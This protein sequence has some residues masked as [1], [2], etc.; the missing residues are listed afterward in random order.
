MIGIEE[1]LNIIDTLSIWDIFRIDVALILKVL[2]VI[3]LTIFIVGSIVSLIVYLLI[4]R[5][6]KKEDK[7]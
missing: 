4:K 1:I 5:D 3:G 6:N 2:P 7:K